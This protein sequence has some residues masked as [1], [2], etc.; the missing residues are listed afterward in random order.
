VIESQSGFV[1]LAI[2]VQKL[3]TRRTAGFSLNAADD[4]TS[5]DDRSNASCCGRRD[6]WSARLTARFTRRG[7][8]VEL[9]R[10]VGVVL[11]RRPFHASLSHKSSMV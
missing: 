6:R 9:K 2:G 3:R 1:S 4:A 11:Y 5:S 10:R 7:L 8:P